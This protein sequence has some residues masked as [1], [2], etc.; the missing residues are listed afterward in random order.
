MRTFDENLKELN[1]LVI[2]SIRN[3]ERMLKI[4][5][6]ELRG[7][8]LNKEL[9]GEAKV[10]EEDINDNERLIDEKVISIIARF[11]PAASDLRFVIGAMNIN[12]E[13]ERV[14]D[15]CINILK[16]IKRLFKEDAELKRHIVPMESLGLKVLKMYEIF[17]DAYVE[18][19]IENAY[20]ILGLDDEI[21]Q[22]KKEYI[23][24]I[25]IKMKEDIEYLDLGIENLLISKNY[26]K[27][28]DEIGTMA[29]TLVYIDR[30]QDLRHKDWGDL[31]ESSSS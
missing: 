30:G 20:L 17:I 23:E 12:R 16:T 5:I 13:L 19:K 27:I 24:K 31:D 9:Y 29:E 21:D 18:R 7:T 28:S 26:E 8:T 10:L 11:Q 14:G 2:E 1:Q 4:T 15:I 6:E 25:K 3:V 22:L